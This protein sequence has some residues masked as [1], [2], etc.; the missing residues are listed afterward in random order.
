MIVDDK[1]HDRFVEFVVTASATV[2][3]KP[4]TGVTVIVEAP[5]TP[6]SP[7]RLVGVAVTVK[8]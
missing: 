7:V 4:L 8:S 3:V 1:V 6:L 5:A 2:P